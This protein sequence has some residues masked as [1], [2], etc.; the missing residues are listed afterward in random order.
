MPQVK[1]SIP[2]HLSQDGA[3]TRIK[4]LVPRLKQKYGN[5]IT[6]V[7]ERWDG[8]AAEFGFRIKGIFPISV[9]GQLNVSEE[10]VTISGNLPAIAGPFQGEIEETIRSEAE[11]L[12][13]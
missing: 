6:D 2:H 13:S 4:N 12:L 3:V 11:K 8:S 9:S 10:S 1:V 7:R 5:R